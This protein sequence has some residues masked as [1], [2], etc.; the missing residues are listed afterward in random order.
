MAT[1]AEE[2]KEAKYSHLNSANAFTPVAIET[3]AVFV[4]RSIT[5]FIMK[6]FFCIIEFFTEKLLIFKIFL[7]CLEFFKL[8]IF[9]E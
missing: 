7:R 4:M 6:T 5:S 9:Y 8:S 3:S 2:R 1:Q